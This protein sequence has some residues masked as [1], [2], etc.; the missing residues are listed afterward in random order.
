MNNNT[1]HKADTPKLTVHGLLGSLSYWGTTARFMLVGVFIAFAFVINLARDG[2]ASFVE[3]EILFLIF[4]LATLVMLDLG[5]VVAARSLP[6]NKVLDR[7]VIMMS[8]LAL[9]AFFVI[10]SLIVI[11]ADGNVVRVVSL[12]IALLIVSVR[13]LV[14]LLFAKRK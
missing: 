10:P 12:I 6:L 5:Y 2:S 3:T 8:D 9:A 13:I 7:W 1:K 4:G 14:G 11:S